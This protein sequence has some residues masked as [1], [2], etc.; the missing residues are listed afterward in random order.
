MKKKFRNLILGIIPNYQLLV[1]INVEYVRRFYSS[2]W[3]KFILVSLEETFKMI[4]LS[5][6]IPNI[7]WISDI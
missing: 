3:I 2:Q 1:Q 6:F 4:D 7:F 5:S